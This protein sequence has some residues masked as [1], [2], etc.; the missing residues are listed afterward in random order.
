MQAVLIFSVFLLAIA[1]S[2]PIG[3][4]M[5]LGATAPIALFHQGGTMGQVLNNAF[6]GAN[7]TPI[8]AVPLFILG[9][10][11]MG[12]AVM[13]GEL[14]LFVL[15]GFVFVLDMLSSLIQRYYF[16]LTHGKRLFRM[17]PFHHHLEKCGWPEGQIVALF[18]GVSVLFCLLAFLSCIL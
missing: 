17:A 16:K 1:L 11:I 8:L 7:S 15:A 2:L 14:L 9:G 18:A 3:I 5:I 10:V 12:C 13:A 4:S 6:S